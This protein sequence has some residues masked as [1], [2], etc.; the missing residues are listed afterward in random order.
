MESRINKLELELQYMRERID[1][2]ERENIEQ[3]NELYE[4][5]NTIES[6]EWAHPKSCVHNDDPWEVWKY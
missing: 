6:K 5:M 3:S 2:L 4:L 1:R